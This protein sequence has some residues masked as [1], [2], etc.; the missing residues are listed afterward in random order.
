MTF[1]KEKLDL[2]NGL[3]QLQVIKKPVIVNAYQLKEDT[4]V[5][6]LEGTMKGKKGDYLMFGVEGEPYICQKNIFE[7]TYRIANNYLDRMKIELEE[8]EER[9]HRLEKYG[10]KKTL[11]KIQLM[12]MIEYKTILES[13]IRE[14]ED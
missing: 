11:T 12:K 9:I 10:D 8:L 2:I 13:R 14:K 5:E 4:E 1:E 3:K 7:K 6:T